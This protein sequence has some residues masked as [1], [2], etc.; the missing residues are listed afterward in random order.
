[1]VLP[2]AR[3]LLAPP[4][5]FVNNPFVDDDRNKDDDDDDEKVDIGESW[6]V[7]NDTGNAFDDDVSSAGSG[8]SD[9]GDCGATEGEN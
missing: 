7:P 1:M 4:R 6:L 8:A 2:S 3:L 5:P 9:D